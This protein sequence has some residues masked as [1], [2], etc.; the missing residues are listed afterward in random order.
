MP[1]IKITNDVRHGVRRSIMR[2]NRQEGFTLIELMIVVAI[3]GILAAIA[4]PAYTSQVKKT[5]RTDAKAALLAAAQSLERC[6]TEYNAYDNAACPALSATSSEG[7][8][9]I[10]ATTLAA[11]SYSLTAAPISGAVIDDTECTTFTIDNKGAQSSTPAGS[12][13]W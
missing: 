4:Y 7:Y 2:F 6:F 13:C 5:Q 12:Q 9:S 11:T 10:T 3:I 8:Y 1:N